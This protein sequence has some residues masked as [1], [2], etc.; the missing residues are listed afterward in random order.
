MIDYDTYMRSVARHRG[1]VRVTRD[2]YTPR[3][4]VLVGWCAPKRFVARV[5]F[6]GA[7]QPLTV[8]LERYGVEV[9]K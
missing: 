5:Q 6:D 8:R 9:I 3:I 2:G 1:R 4:G 7:A